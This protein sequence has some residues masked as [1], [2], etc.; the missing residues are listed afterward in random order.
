MPAALR[1]ILG[2]APRHVVHEQRR[3]ALHLRLSECKPASVGLDPGRIADT[4]QRWGEMRDPRSI[5]TE[6]LPVSAGAEWGEPHGL[7]RRPDFPDPLRMIDGTPIESREE[8]LSLRKPELLRLF[9]NYEYGCC[10]PAP[11][12]VKWAVVYC[13]ERALGGKATIR[14]ILVRCSRPTAEF[15]LML[16]TP[17]QFKEHLACLLGL[18]FGGNHAVTE[19]PGIAVTTAWMREG[20]ARRAT[21]QRGEIG[22]AKARRGTSLSALIADTA[23]R[24]SSMAKSPRTSR[25]WGKGACSRSSPSSMRVAA[26]ARGR[27]TTSA[28]SVSGRGA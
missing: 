10:L 27:A 16:V 20:T 2:R 23:L 15:R 11:S 4:E 21:K 17:N 12:E 7:P 5:S 1:A 26:M 28:C 18:N 24:R 19:D 25:R 14:E 22:G 13:N 9:Q 6:P 8:W 3:A